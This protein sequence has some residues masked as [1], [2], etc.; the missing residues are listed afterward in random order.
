[1]K[2]VNYP[3]QEQFLQS[4]NVLTIIRF[5][6]MT[7]SP[8]RGHVNSEHHSNK[9]TYFFLNTIYGVTNPAYSIIPFSFRLSISLPT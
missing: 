7:K 5:F 8:A 9:Y 3:L 6:T 1:M 4:I 2:M